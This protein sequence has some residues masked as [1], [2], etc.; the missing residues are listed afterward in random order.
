SPADLYLD[1][2]LTYLGQAQRDNLFRPFYS[3]VVLNN[4][5]SHL[6]DATNLWTLA[7]YRARVIMY[8]TNK[9]SESE[10]STYQA[11]GDDKWSNRLCVRTST[12]SYNQALGAFFVKHLGEETT[13]QVLSSWVK[14]FS[15]APIAND[16]GV[17]QAIADGQCDVGIANT[18]YLPAF[19]R[20]N[21]DFPV[22]IFFPNQNDFGAHVNGVGIGI[23]KYTKNFKEANMLLEYFT[24]AEVQTPVAAA[25]SQYPVNPKANIIQILKDFGSFKEDTTNISEISRHIDTAN[26]IFKEVNYK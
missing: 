25:F 7:F 17:I 3:K 14:N 26:K 18:Y 16:R 23:A 8:N 20:N 10:L 24:S 4:V 11:L 6:R 12:N 21:P 5:P 13:L 19:I 9:V 2:D 22:R 15:T 1:K